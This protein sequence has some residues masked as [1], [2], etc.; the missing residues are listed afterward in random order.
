MIFTRQTIVSNSIWKNP[1][2]SPY[3]LW[4]FG[5]PHTLIGT[6][7]SIISTFRFANPSFSI[8]RLLWTLMLCSLINL[9]ITGINQVYDISIDRINK[10]H[11]VIPSNRIS[12]QNAKWI[13]LIALCLG[14]FFSILPVSWNS[15]PLFLLLLLSAVTGTFYSIEPFRCKVN[16]IA[17]MI[18]IILVRGIFIPSLIFHHALNTPLGNIEVCKILGTIFYFSILSG[19]IALMKDVPDAK[20]DFIYGIG[21]FTL[22][23]GSL[24]IISFANWVHRF[25]SFGIASIFLFSTFM[26]THPSR[27]F[28]QVLLSLFFLING[29][30]T[31]FSHR[32]PKESYK[33]LWDYFY[34]SYMALPFLS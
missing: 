7:L 27:M 11:L 5:R 10:Q 19:L 28:V 33:K 17:A 20:G 26:N 25:L 9:Y 16:P 21:T 12:L 2:R 29:C 34:F 32:N 31:P 23:Y 3:D 24:K 15:Q 1:I 8:G 22:H 14:L 30:I 6:G 4:E 13:A 18:C